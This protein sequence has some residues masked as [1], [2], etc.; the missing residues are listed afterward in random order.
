[1]SGIVSSQKHT[2]YR[3]DIDGLRAIA[4]F[5]VLIFHAFPNWINGGFVGVDI[6]FVISGFLISSVILKDLRRDTFS[7]LDFYMRRVRRIFPALALVLATCLLLGWFLAYPDEYQS[8]GKHIAAGAAF[9][10]NIALWRETGYFDA[11]AETKPLLHLW[12]LGIEEQFYIVWPL[13]V[14]FLYRRT[15]GSLPIVSVLAL[16]S[17]SLNIWFISSKPGATFYLPVTRF[18]ELLAGSLLAYVTSFHGG[19]AGA[20]ATRFPPLALSPPRLRLFH[21]LSSWTGL[22]LISAA[23]ALTDS[24]AFPG[25][26]A[27]LPTI[28]SFLLISAGPEAWFNRRVLSHGAF[29]FVGLISYPLYL[30]HWPLLTFARYFEFGQISLAVRGMVVV[31]S[32]FFAWLTY[33]WLETPIRTGNLTR[34]TPAILVVIVAIFAV[35]GLGIFLDKGPSARLGHNALALDLD[36]R[37]SADPFLPCSNDMANMSTRIRQPIDYCVQSSPSAP[38]VAVFG[39]SHAEHIYPG[40]AQSDHSR[41]WLLVGHNSCPPVN[42]INVEGDVLHCRERSE[43]ITRSL[44]RMESIRVVVL[45]FFGNYFLDSDVAADHLANHIGPSTISIRSN[46]TTLSGKKDLFFFGLDRTIDI[47]E[48]AGKNVVVVVDIPE[49]PF[50]PRDKLR[51]IMVMN[52]SGQ[53]VS[54]AKSSVVN[55]QSQLRAGIA[56]LKIAHPALLT[57]DPLEFLCDDTSCHIVIDDI[58]IYR[59]SHHLSSRGSMLFARKFLPVLTRSTGRGSAG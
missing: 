6:F 12:S 25:W 38:V 45:A 18:W 11:R 29:V 20:L 33:R 17:F 9:V 1:M 5:A 4:I 48:K 28:G 3:P 53:S 13:L 43:E 47:L 2:Q 26:W 49:L 59:D 7:Y 55:R 51:Y 23:I 56:Q 22:L 27:L 16:A 39:D 40:L 50:F 15:R 44:A 10:S 36:Q 32:I 58:L 24:R 14:A 41:N 42:G 46:E 35:C 19:L 21:N 54:Q 34:R 37:P 8:L 52:E 57:Y 31:L 30:W